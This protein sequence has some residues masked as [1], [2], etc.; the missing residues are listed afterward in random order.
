MIRNRQVTAIIPVRG[1]SKGIPRKNLLPLAGDKSMLVDT[2]SRVE[3]LS[4]EPPTVICNDAHRFIVAE[5]L[6]ESG[7][8]GG[9]IILEPV[10]RNTAPAVAVAAM[11]ALESD[12]EAIL[13]VLPADHLIQQPEVFREAVRTAE[14]QA[15]AGRLVTFGVVPP[16]FRVAFVAAVSF[17]WVFVL[18]SVAGS[19]SSTINYNSRER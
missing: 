13:L 18:S 10:G 11:R 17:F 19:S 14:P 1:G 7:G 3:G 4:Q 5:Q 9:D 6:R 8:S 2:L 16:H 12:P 15:R